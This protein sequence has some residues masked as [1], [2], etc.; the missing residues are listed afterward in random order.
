MDFLARISSRRERECGILIVNRADMPVVGVR[1]RAELVIEKLPRPR[2]PRML[3]VGHGAQIDHVAQEDM[4][5][6]ALGMVYS[7]AT[8]LSRNQ[9]LC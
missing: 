4:V 6:R 1:G 9:W 3:L 8:G 5:V 7:S 2:L